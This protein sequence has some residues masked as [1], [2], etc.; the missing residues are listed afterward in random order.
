MIINLDA[1]KN[2]LRSEQNIWWKKSKVYITEFLFYS[3]NHSLENEK[4]E[5]YDWESFMDF[6]K[7]KNDLFVLIKT[8]LKDVSF[9]D[10]VHWGINLEDKRKLELIEENNQILTYTFACFLE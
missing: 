5:F 4:I 2:H 7:N 3:D 1:K 6:C 10:F 8:E 9:E